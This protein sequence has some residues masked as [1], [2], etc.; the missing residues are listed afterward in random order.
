[1]PT[2]DWIGK[3][4]VLNHHRRVPYR[5]L[6]CDPKL[7]AGD[8]DSGNLLVQGDNL[9]ALKALL[10]YYAGKVKC[11]YIDPPYNTG[12]EKWVYNDA[13]NSPEM[14]NWLGRVVGAEAEDLSRHDKWLCMMYPRLSLLRQFLTDDGA[15]FV[16]IDD[17]EVG[18]L[19]TLLSEVFGAPNFVCSFIW[20]KKHTRANDAEFVSDN[21]DFLLLYARDKTKL[22]LRRLP[23]TEAA[24]ARFKNPDDDPR[25]P[26]ISQPLQVKTPSQAYIYEIV[27]PQGRQ[28]SPPNGRS[29]AF[30]R[31][32]YEE[33][34]R[35][36]RIYFG[37]DGRNVPRLKKFLPEVGDLV[38]VTIWPR[39]E[40]GD[41]QEAKTELKT[42][43]SNG[44]LS[45]DNPKPVR[46]LARVLQ[47]ATQKN[48]IVLDSFAGSGTTAHALL[49]L[50]KADGGN[51]RF[52]I[53]EIDNDIANEVTARRLRVVIQGDAEEF[54][55]LGG[56]FRFCRLGEPLFDEA[57]N[58]RD[59]VKFP[60][61]AAHVFFTETGSPIP[62]RA[63]AR[64]PLLGVHN[65]IAIYLLFNGVMGDKRPDGGNVLTGPILHDLPPHHGPKV[66][67]AESSRL[68]RS[69]LK[70]E[71]IVFKQVPYEIR[72][73]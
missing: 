39:D 40:V 70:R 48:S 51:R 60:D 71:G 11:I 52:L 4:A 46:L 36:G 2:L 21:H 6:H 64:S 58:I 31:E 28:V 35:D 19:R 67:Y 59:S 30:G 5:L 9:L 22:R 27:T 10:P 66:I 26:W 63:T 54:L 1:M 69:R 17:N 72:V 38:P 23:R 34:V 73:S 32:R 44:R 53:V 15:I 56:G 14:R 41:N 33:L 12:N 16:S 24:N 55:P 13:V 20:E 61:L 18:H 8:P 37:P 45:F 65:G 50:N 7:S 3:K 43:L 25:G 42:L 57:G 62:K 29:W 49:A 68:G 47:L